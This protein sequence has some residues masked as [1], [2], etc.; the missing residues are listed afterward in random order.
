MTREGGTTYSMAVPILRAGP[1]AED[2]S[3]VGQN[4]GPGRAANAAM[5]AAAAAGFPYDD[6]AYDQEGEELPYDSSSITETEDAD[7]QQQWH[8]HQHGEVD[9]GSRAAPSAAA[10]VTVGSQQQQD[11]GAFKEQLK[12]LLVEELVHDVEDLALQGDGISGGGAVAAVLRTDS[13]KG[14]SEIVVALPPGVVVDGAG[15]VMSEQELR[16][17]AEQELQRLL[18]KDAGATKHLDE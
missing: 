9:A 12:E 7:E 14:E 15:G 8:Q 18:S 3:V 4:G 13:P 10:S 6:D 17:A 2:G 1:Y 5:A 11:A 16:E